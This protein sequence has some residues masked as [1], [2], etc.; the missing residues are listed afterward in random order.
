MKYLDN[1]GRE[2]KVGNTVVGKVESGLV[3]LRVIEF[4]PKKVKCSG[5]GYSGTWYSKDLMVIPE[6]L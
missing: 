5:S 1:N 3:T 6:P 2:I 4:T